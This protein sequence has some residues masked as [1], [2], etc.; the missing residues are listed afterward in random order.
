MIAL[1]ALV[2]CAGCGGGGG[3][4]GGG[5]ETPAVVATVNPT[6][7]GTGDLVTVTAEVPFTGIISVTT[8][9][10]GDGTGGSIAP[11]TMANLSGT[12]TW[13]RSFTVASGADGVYQVTVTAATEADGSQ[14]SA[15]VELT[16]E[17]DGGGGGDGDPPPPPW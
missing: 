12:Q 2:S 16:I 14:S 9:F 17:G 6:T 1:L 13:R 3:A 4:G 11:L 10:V 15:P 5:G 7:A 8:T